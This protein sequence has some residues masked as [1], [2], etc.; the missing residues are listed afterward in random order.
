MVAAAGAFAL[1]AAKAAPDVWPAELISS[2]A[3][4]AMLAAS[5][6]CLAALLRKQLR[7]GLAATGLAGVAAFIMLDAI[8]SAQ[9]LAGAARPD[10]PAVVW[11]NVYGNADAFE[12]A[13][14]L[15]IETDAVVLAIAEAPR[16]EI[17]DAL[18]SRA[19]AAYP[20]EAAPDPESGVLLMSRLPLTD[21]RA[22]SFGYKR[23][24]AAT[25]NV[26]GVDVDILAVHLPTPLS[27]TGQ[28]WR[29]R[30]WQ[31]T[32]ALLRPAAPTVMVGDFNATPWSPLVRG[33]VARAGFA[34]ATLG[35]RPTWFSNLPGIG[36]P[37]DHAFATEAL[38]VDARIGPDTP[39]DH[40]PLIVR[41]RIAGE[42][43]ASP[44]APAAAR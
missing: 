28:F 2:L 30:F 37:I 29:A 4:Q 16:E 44:A 20:F 18:M 17:P 19:R 27:P 15:A 6:L 26:K 38:E 32:A 36:L 23:S 10:D 3:P 31:E 33:D 43:P 35:L 41:F 39:S 1:L 13:F 8:P 34:R 11:S 22:T 12:A 21:E 9:G 42:G 40:Y 5:V 24:V 7:P 25:V 14:E